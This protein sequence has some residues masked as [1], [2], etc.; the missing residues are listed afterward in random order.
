MS[1]SRNRTYSTNKKTREVSKLTTVGYVVFIENGESTRR[2]SRQVIPVSSISGSAFF[3]GTTT[4]KIT[5]SGSS[6]VPLQF[7]TGSFTIE[8]WQKLAPGASS[9]PRVFEQ[10]RPIGIMALM[11]GDSTSRLFFIT[12]GTSGSVIGNMTGSL[13]DTWN[14]FAVVRSGSAV[15][16]LKVYRNGVQLGSAITNNI[17]FISTDPI[18][19]GNIASGTSVDAFSG[20]ITNFHW[21]K[22]VAKYTASFT[23]TGPISPISGSS[24]LL[25]LTTTSA[26]LSIDSSGYNRTMINTNTSF[27][28]DSPF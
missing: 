19:I 9:F 24:A 15:G 16:N 27:V 1:Y 23:P 12:L 20:S 26:S 18:T 3:N 2:Y 13:N 4:S 10:P 25:L 11:P 5:T 6:D 7:G 22:G 8:W 17:N 28:Q 14:H 21:L